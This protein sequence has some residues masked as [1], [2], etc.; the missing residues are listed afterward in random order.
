MTPN[1]ALDRCGG[2]ILAVDTHPSAGAA[3]E[4]DVVVVVDIRQVAGVET[5]PAHP[6][7][8]RGRVVP[9][10][11]EQAGPVG[12]HLAHGL[13]GIGELTV[14]VEPRARTLGSGLRIHDPHPSGQRAERGVRGVGR[15]RDGQP[16]LAGAEPVHHAHAEAPRELGPH[17]SRRLVAVDDAHGVVVV[18]GSF[19]GRQDV[20]QRRAHVVGEGAAVAAHVLQPARRGEA[21]ALRDRALREQGDR[22]RHHHGVGVEQRHRAVDAVLGAHPEPLGE[23][24]A[25]HRDF[26][27]GDAHGL[28][29]AAGAGGEHQR[30]QVVGARG[31]VRRGGQRGAGVAGEQRRPLRRV[32]REHRDAGVEAVEER[33]VVGVGEDDR[34]VGER[35]VAQ[36]GLAAPR[37]V[38]AGHDQLGAGRRAEQVE[39]LRAAGHEQA[40]VGVGGRA[41]TT[42]RRRRRRSRRRRDQFPQGGDPHGD[43]AGRLRPRQ[44]LAV[45][46]DPAILDPGQR[47]DR[48]GDG[49]ERLRGDVGDRADGRAH[50]E[51]SHGSP[52]VARTS[53]RSSSC[54]VAPPSRNSAA[55]AA[56]K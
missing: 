48:V 41:G 32:D 34:A 11:G 2:Q 33:G 26:G 1:H 40:D 46:P 35:G 14:G 15:P 30:H 12:D 45:G 19:G 37:G 27:L 52:V 42:R 7:G 23:H 29:V 6:L 25:R 56:R 49:V 54:R 55:L 28:G 20:G 10:A 13:V 53:P 50:A 17:I 47:A 18:V 5:S 36:E 4:V 44:E 9:V 3:G 43:L 8:V 51:Y 21:A 22:P 39:V 16:A 24:P 38:E 31:H